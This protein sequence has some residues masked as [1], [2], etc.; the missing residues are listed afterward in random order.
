MACREAE[1]SKVILDQATQGV[2][3]HGERI[4]DRDEVQDD[5]GD[6]P[7]LA[8]GSIPRAQIRRTPVIPWKI[9]AGRPACCRWPR[10]GAS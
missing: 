3:L 10:P 4:A 6:Q 9:R 5:A 2:A 8:L 7:G 1:A